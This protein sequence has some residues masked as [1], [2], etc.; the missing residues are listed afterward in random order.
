MSKVDFEFHGIPV[1]PPDDVPL[2]P[3]GCAF[4]EFQNSMEGWKNE[5][6]KRGRIFWTPKSGDKLRHAAAN[7]VVH[8]LCNV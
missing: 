2:G 1:E 6:V 4:I 8:I 7:K 5:G 3:L